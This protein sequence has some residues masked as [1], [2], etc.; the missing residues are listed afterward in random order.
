MV[1]TKTYNVL[2]D[3]IV[4]TS[5]P[6]FNVN[7]NDLKT[8]KLNILINQGK[9]PLDLTGA[10]VRLAIKKP[11][12]KTV[13][14]DCTIV[15]PLTGSCEIILDTQA[16]AVEGSYAAEV[17][18]YYET[19]TVAVT[20]SFNYTAKKGIL[21]DD[22]IE[23]TNEWQSITQAIAD[24]EAL[25]T[26]L[27]TNGTGIDTQARADIQTVT[28]QLAQ[29][30]KQLKTEKVRTTSFATKK[31]LFTIIDDDGYLEALNVLKPLLD[32]RG[33][34]G[35]SAIITN[36]VGGNGYMT[37]DQI[38]SLRDS[39]WE[40]LSHTKSHANMT[41]TTPD[42]QQ[43]EINGSLDTLK[44]QGFDVKGIV[45]PYDNPNS[46]AK[47][48]ANLAYS[49]AF[50]IWGVNDVP[51]D[52][53]QI[54]R[55][56]ISNTGEPDYPLE[57][58]TAKVDDA[59]ANNK[60]MILETHMNFITQPNLQILIQL[61][62]YVKTKETNGEIQV[63]TPAQAYD[64]FGNIIESRNYETGAYSVVANNG[65]SYSS[66][67][68]RN[69]QMKT[70]SGIAESSPVTAFEK[71]RSTIIPF[72]TADNFGQGAGVLITHRDLTNDDLSCQEWFTLDMKQRWLRAWNTSSKSWF[73][74]RKYYPEGGKY[75]TYDSTSNARR[76]TDL[77]STFPQGLTV[78]VITDATGFP[79]ARPGM[80]HTYRFETPDAGYQWQEYHAYGKSNIVY[81][82]STN[83][84]TG[85]WL[86]WTRQLL[87]SQV[88]YAMTAK[89]IPA[90]SC[91]DLIVPFFDVKDYSVLYA[92][93]GAT[94]LESNVGFNIYYYNDN[95]CLLRL[96]NPTT[97][98]INLAARTW[99]LTSS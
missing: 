10:T 41:L 82:R 4:T 21:N 50:G 20:S 22:T 18:V 74:W 80:L 43:I 92:S 85:D 45:W 84:S 90:N 37:W 32:A 86:G 15:D 81:R 58:F 7:T 89:T 88:T 16:Y 71:G 70:P 61:L 1:K 65:E 38:R 66:G 95:N 55:I 63:V 77:A 94:V 19:D 33:W 73:A 34:K 23:S 87:A 40:I 42:Q 17:M 24:N 28:T 26:D 72:Y 52:S 76:A 46:N 75:V 49:Y 36:F 6:A 29:S 97:T 67:I 56:A 31:P 9:E 54:A 39:G 14:Q 3:T 78:T 99:T 51:I 57:F 25:L 98:A 30:A 96:V 60:W 2:L 27:R 91:L 8:V 35:A 47:K 53:M 69:Y 5:N 62:D 59:I 11:D 93:P 13:L 83:T 48:L 68:F 12:K 44:S 79:I 64:I